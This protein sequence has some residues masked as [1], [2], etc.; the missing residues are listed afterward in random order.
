MK[1]ITLSTV[2]TSNSAVAPMNIHTSPFNVGFGVTVSGVV[3]YTVQHTFDDVFSSTF[4]PATANWFDHPT[5]ASQSTAKDGNYA[6][7]VTGIRLKGVSGA[8]TATIIIVQAG[9]Q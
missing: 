7:P 9:I 5:I 2:G 6:F 4:N 8:G 3:T 1:P